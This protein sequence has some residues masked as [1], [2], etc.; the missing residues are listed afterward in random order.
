MTEEPAPRPWN[1][2]LV[3][4]ANST[5]GHIYVV[6]ANG[7]KIAAVWGRPEEKHATAELIIRAVN[8][9]QE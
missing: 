9:Q 5:R 2:I 6:D 3:G 7:R 4:E 1:W 8:E